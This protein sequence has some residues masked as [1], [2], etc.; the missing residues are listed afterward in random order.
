MHKNVWCII[1]EIAI[2][3]EALIFREVL[4]GFWCPLVTPIVQIYYNI[5]RPPALQ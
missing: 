1:R 2:L 3:Q 5:T 4:D